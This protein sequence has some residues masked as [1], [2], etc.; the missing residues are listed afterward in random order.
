MYKEAIIWNPIK[1]CLNNCNYCAYRT[2]A[3]RQMPKFDEDGNKIRGCQECYAFK[4]HFHEERLNIN[5]NRNKYETTGDRFIW[6]CSSSDICF[7]KKEWMDKVLDVVRKFPNRTFFFQ[8][9]DPNCFE[10]YEFPS[11]TIIGI[12]L[13]TNV[14]DGY[15]QFSKAPLPSKRFEAFV[16]IKHPRKTVTIEPILK[17]NRYIFAI[18]I[19]IISPIWV[20]IGCDSHKNKLDEP[21][22]AKTLQLIT[23]L[24]KITIVKEK[25]IRS[26][27]YEQPTN[28]KL[29][30]TLVGF[31]PKKRSTDRSEGDIIMGTTPPVDRTICSNCGNE[32]V[33]SNEKAHEYNCLKCG[34]SIL[35]L[36]SN[37]KELRALKKESYLEGRHW[38]HG[39]GLNR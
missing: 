4:P 6:A 11:N 32:M 9:K 34:R 35:L 24:K 20:W 10:K 5:F 38:N 1:G 15:D 2:Q 33:Q 13:E 31:Y 29:P 14:D 22:L 3:Y 27:W 19:K 16:K 8:T 30:T 18:W 25:L 39:G 23:E 21:T 37:A 12:T 28:N 7:A 36:N 17:F 26:A